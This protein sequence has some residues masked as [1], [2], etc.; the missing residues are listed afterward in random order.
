[1]P[2]LYGPL[3]VADVAG[4]AFFPVFRELGA[5]PKHAAA[6]VVLPK[7]PALGDYRDSDGSRGLRPSISTISPGLTELTELGF[8]RFLPAQ[9]VLARG[10]PPCGARPGRIGEFGQAVKLVAAPSSTAG[11]LIRQ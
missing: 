11:S 8:A 1:V 10:A 7:T 3:V 2:H 4:R 6:R 9:I 5:G